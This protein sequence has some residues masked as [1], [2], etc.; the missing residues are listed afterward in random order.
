MILSAEAVLK[1]KFWNGLVRLTRRQGDV[2][3]NLFF[4][5]PIGNI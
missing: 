5:W 4:I 1:L 3:L 2:F